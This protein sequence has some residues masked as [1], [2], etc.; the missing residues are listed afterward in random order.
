MTKQKHTADNLML[1]RKYFNNLYHLI[2]NRERDLQKYSLVATRSGLHNLEINHGSTASLMYSRYNPWNEAEIWA[3]KSR[4]SIGDSQHIFIY[5]FG[6]GYHVEQLIDKYPDRY[7][8]ILEPEVDIMLAALESRD[9]SK[10]FKHGNIGVFAIGKDELTS[11]LFVNNLTTQLFKSFHSVYSPYYLSNYSEEISKVNTLFRA[12]VISERTNHSTMKLFKNE[13]PENIL[14][15]LKHLLNTRSLD[16]LKGKLNE[17]PAIVVGSG[18]SLNTDIDYLRKYQDKAIIFAAGS[19]IQ[20][21]LNQG[22][23]PHIVVSI[24]GSE[25]NYEAFKDMNLTSIPFVFGSYL[26]NRILED[27]QSQE[28]VYHCFIATDTITSHLMNIKDKSRLFQST[29]SVTGIVMQL[30]AYLGTKT[31]VL[32]GQDLS[33]PGN[34]VHA[35]QVDHFTDEEKKKFVSF[36]KEEVVNVQGGKNPA[37]KSM[38]NTLEN[39]EHLIAAYSNRIEFINT[40]RIGARIKGTEEIPFEHIESKVRFHEITPDQVRQ[41]MKEKTSPYSTHEQEQVYNRLL[42]CKDE[43]LSFKEIWLK[44]AIEELDLLKKRLGQRNE[45]GVEKSLI[46]INSV[47]EKIVGSFVFDPI[48]GIVVQS[49]IMIYKRYVPEILREQHML[50]RGELVLDH[51][52]ALIVAI[53][54]QTPIVIELME[55]VLKKLK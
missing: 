50:K 2:R 28:D 54:E 42:K 51:L 23:R 46:S 48:F 38:M 39:I 25:K 7:I 10:I 16:S 20:A 36:A 18:P 30:A 40:S 37:T 24:D 35:A 15:N 52:G 5:G 17:Y 29:A 26:K 11:M 45:V 41:F 6:L 43:L 14:L 9:L 27:M 4:E 53:H 13:W 3:E 12:S 47:W 34:V 44:D 21:L 55:S 33:Y 8:H 19:S 31:I 32:V 1:V 22:V 49:Q